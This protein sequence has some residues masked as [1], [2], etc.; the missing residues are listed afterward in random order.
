MNS[1]WMIR[2]TAVCLA[3]MLSA[4]ATGEEAPAPAETAAVHAEPAADS[5]GA[6]ADAIEGQDG[7]KSGEASE[8]SGNGPEAERTQEAAEPSEAAGTEQTPSQTGEAPETPAAPDV[9]SEPSEGEDDL[10]N[11]GEE[12]DAP[13]EERVI[14][15]FAPFAQT[16]WVLPEKPALEEALK[17]FPGALEARL[18]DGQTARVEVTWRCENYE[19]E[20]ES[21]A[22]QSVL[23]EEGYA[24]GEGAALPSVNLRI[25]ASDELVF[26]DFTFRIHEDGALTLQS[27]LGGA[28]SVSVPERVEGRPVIAL[29]ATAFAGN[30]RLESLALPKGLLAV[31]GGAL[32][33]CARLKTVELPDSLERVGAGVFA[34]C[35]ALEK[36]RLNISLETTVTDGR[37]YT[38]KV[39][40]ENGDVRTV[41]VELDDP[42]TDY[43]VLDGGAWMQQGEIRIDRE[44]VAAVAGGGRLEIGPAA[45]ITVLGSLSCSGSA[46]NEGRVVACAGAVSGV[47]GDVVREHAWSD[48]VCAVCGAR[49]ALTLTVTPRQSSFERTYD[50]ASGMD[51]GSDDFILEGVREGDEVTLAAVNLD[52]DEK[53]AGS[54]LASASFELGGANGGDY[55]VMPVEISVVIHPKEVTVT[56][57]SGQSKAY[58]EKDPS[59][60]AGYRGAVSGESLVGALSREKG[61]DVGKY[62]ILAGTLQKLNPNYRI[63]LAEETFEITAKSISAGGVTLAKVPNQR[64]TGSALEPDVELL[65]GSAALREGRDYTLSYENNTEV[66]TA[67]VTVTGK[68]NYTGSRSAAFQIIKV[69]SG[70]GGGGIPP[71]DFGGTD[72]TADDT[73]EASDALILDGEDWGAV[74][75]DETGAAWAFTQSSRQVQQDET[76]HTVLCLTAQA[77]TEAFGDGE[78]SEYGELRLRLNLALIA[79]IRAAGYTDVE[80]QVGEAELRVPLDTLYA[81]Y[82]GESG[83]LS[84]DYYELRLWMLDGS[85]AACEGY[86]TVTT[87]VRCEVLAAPAGEDAEGEDVLSLLDGVLL[88]LVPEEEPDY[89]NTHYFVLRAEGADSDAVHEP[90]GAMFI[91]DASR[92]KCSLTPV[93]GGT[94]ALAVREEE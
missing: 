26:G 2:V 92:V 68:G 35:S 57:R 8:P 67:T 84:V 71:C 10:P 51:V 18:A 37:G 85:E 60:R 31:E 56:P 43:C 90:E 33:N 29:A 48:G 19:A 27:Y 41:H 9:P 40:E 88:R 42:F 11:S 73:T 23:S 72:L 55:S 61:E 83:T 58:G 52:F 63:V 30:E 36:V 39:V 82:V 87:P 32:K 44:H 69:S 16:E 91:L 20:A 74:L 17:L 81:E 79:G 93:F 6:E 46:V 86:R 65:D 94:Y 25:E 64:Y 12:E 66:G 14:L 53:D 75:F 13:K 77:R 54:Y 5:K 34:G 76:V 89:E 38:R 70:S 22:F 47:D 62:K 45:V 15:S 80:L 49:Q 3:L 7:P 28:S 21:Y 59:L 78:A 1:K 4:P 24:L 50:G